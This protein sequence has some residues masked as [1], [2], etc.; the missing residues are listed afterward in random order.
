MTGWWEGAFCMCNILLCM[1]VRVRIIV[2]NMY[3]FNLD[4]ATHPAIDTRGHSSTIHSFT[5]TVYILA[6]RQPVFSLVPLG[7][8]APLA[9]GVLLA[10]IK[11]AVIY[12]QVFIFSVHHPIVFSVVVIVI[13][14]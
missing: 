14:L 13:I 6:E 9:R 2:C 11:A 10:A 5:T 1:D 4:I 8:A 12:C 3:K 7:C